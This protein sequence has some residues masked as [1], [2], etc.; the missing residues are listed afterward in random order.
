MSSEVG[1]HSRETSRYI[2]LATQVISVSHPQRDRNVVAASGQWLCFLAGEVT[3]GLHAAQH[4]QIRS[5]GL[6]GDEYLAY[7]THYGNKRVYIR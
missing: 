2:L 4:I 7:G 1:D 3:A 6:K 5:Y